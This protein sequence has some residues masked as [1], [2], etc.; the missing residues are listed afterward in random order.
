MQVEYVALLVTGTS[1]NE[2]VHRVLPAN[3]QV[4]I[5]RVDNSLDAIAVL[6]QQAVHLIISEIDIGSIDGWRLARLVRANVLKCD[7]HTPFILLSS[8]YCERITETTA[9]AYGINLVV[10]KQQ[11]AELPRYINHL[12]QKAAHTQNRQC[13]LVVEDEPDIAELARR[14]LQPNYDVVIAATGPQALVCFAEQEF[15]LVLL[16]V[17]LPGLN[18]QQVLAEM[19][20]QKP[21]QSVVVMTA[22]GGIEIAE[23]MMLQGAADFVSKP[24]RAEQLRRVIDVATQREDFLVSNEQFKQKVEQL[25]G[26]EERYRALSLVH[27]RVLD[28]VS[29]VLMELDPSGN[30]RFANKAWF[31]LVAGSSLQHAG[32]LG[33][34]FHPADRV[35]FEQQLLALCQGKAQQWHIELQLMMPQCW[36]A[37]NMA[38]L[39]DQM[40][41]VTVT[42]ENIEERKRA[43]QELQ[44]LAMHDPLTSLYNR[45]FF[46]R[47]LIRLA[48]LASAEQTHALLY[49][50]L[51][52]FKVINDSHGH[53]HGD[54]ILREVALRLAKELS[55][56]DL[57]CRVGGD[58]FVVLTQ[59]KSMQQAVELA[60]QLCQQLQNRPYTLKDKVYSL[61]CSIGISLIDGSMSDAQIYL[62]QSDIA[63][64]VAK[65]KGR[66]R[67]H[68]YSVQ[69]SASHTLQN[70]LQWSQQLREAIVRDQIVLH[71]QPVV[72]V[73][74]KAV[75]YFE[76]LVRLSLADRLVYPGDFIQALEQVED[77]N[78]LDHQVI[79]KT[80]A[81]M[82]RHPV[83]KK[84]AINLS[85]QAF[86]DERL[87]PLIEQKLQ[88]YQVSPN[89]IVFELTE[90]ASLNNISGTYAM[91][92]Q[93]TSLG[94]EFS[95]DDFGTGFSTFSYLKQLPSGSIK[96]DGSFVRNMH[97]DKMDFTLV[98]SM[99]EIA[100]AL[101]R[102]TVAEFVEN[103]DI[104]AMLAPLGIDYA[105]GY[106]ISK[107]LPIEK[108]EKTF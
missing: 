60:E 17:M 58:E 12:L 57:L 53:S 39:P 78:L 41:G 43:E 45:H 14:I 97:Q 107:P 71:F 19:M 1:M 49:I 72:C 102:K 9:R 105:Q 29:T 74:T 106:H 94:C 20:R 6:K 95:I 76:A 101:G 93:L 47:E 42:L 73:K 103:A 92:E 11:L 38:Q 91:I 96:I 55:A 28:H 25:A 99:A 3:S 27:Q 61:S 62:Q 69:D 85:A 5:I 32:K 23:Q 51:D 82:S 40:T 7:E 81:M 4:Q 2:A 89:R 18:G 84:V 65:D 70:S 21:Q 54:A 67:A 8:T 59:D 13:I 75:V 88:Q 104:F 34:F 16:D 90:T 46:D 15:T 68:C 30:I 80:I 87:V 83:L 86:K 108:I 36:V 64:Y 24:F 44:H 77:I 22:H 35:L 50:D 37:L 98:K 10:A 48:G 26:S 66:N 63:L 31:D 79:A 52:H 100:T 33:S 56:T